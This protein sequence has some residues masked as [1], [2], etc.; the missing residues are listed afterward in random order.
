MNEI[1]KRIRAKGQS[2]F[3]TTAGILIFIQ[4]LTPAFADL[5]IDLVWL[6]IVTG[7]VKAPSLPIEEKR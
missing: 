5:M 2:L 1:F 6:A 3:Y 7:Y 4:L